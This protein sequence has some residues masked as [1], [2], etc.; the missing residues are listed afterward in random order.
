MTMV[1][2]RPSK[3][4]RE[5]GEQLAR[6]CD[7]AEAEQLKQFP[8]M[9]RRCA[10]CAFRKGTFPNGCVATTMDAFKAVME[11]VDFMCHHSPQDAEGRHT[12]WCQGWFLLCS[13]QKGFKEV[14][15]EFS[16]VE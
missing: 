9:K 4:G 1:P 6:L 16:H 13:Q 3:E 11:G 2:N 12:E 7:A 15:W 10:S 8:D 14:P 5:L